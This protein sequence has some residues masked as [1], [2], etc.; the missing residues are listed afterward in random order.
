MRAARATCPRATPRRSA[1]RTSPSQR[2]SA[3]GSLMLGLKKR[4]LTVRTSTVT[5]RAPTTP[6][7]LPYPV[8]LRIMGS[9]V[10]YDCT[11]RLS[12]PE[13]PAHSVEKPLP[14][15]QESGHVLERGRADAVG[16]VPEDDRVEDANLDARREHVTV[17]RDLGAATQRLRAPR[18][19]EERVTAILVGR[20]GEQPE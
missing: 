16:G 8:M 11:T 10:T 14:R 13:L 19:R 17:H 7:A 12:I 1:S 6:V 18:H 9:L 2:A 15:L 4:W 5:R 20:G 3:S